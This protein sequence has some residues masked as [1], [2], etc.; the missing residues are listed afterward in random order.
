M[1][2]VQDLADAV[3]AGD[4]S[5][6]RILLHAKPDLIGTDMSEGDEH[7]A[8]HFAVLKR[9][10]AMVKLLM[11]AGA[12]AHKG[13]WPHRDATSA[14][15]IARER[16]YGEIVAIIEEEERRRREELSCPNATVAPVQEQINAAIAEHDNGL[17]IRLLEADGSLIHACDRKG[18]TPLHIAAQE[19]NEEMV[20]W[21]LHKRAKVNK[22]DLRDYTPLDRAALGADPRND[23]AK[24]FPAIATLLM[25]HGAEVTIYGAVALGGA[26]RVYELLQNDPSLLRRIDTNG[27]LVSLAVNHG[28]IEIAKLLLD[29]GAD[30]DERITLQAVEKPTASWGMLC[31]MPRWRMSATWLSCCSI[32]GQIR[33]P[34]C[35]HQAGRYEMP[36]ITKTSQSRNFCSR[37]A[38]SHSPIWLPRLT[39]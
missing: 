14:L 32:A 39:M 12:D 6:V 37:T 35:M 30:V 15:T 17:A 9:N 26:A 25:A 22:R 20:E 13:I 11:E 21:L 38:L 1:M 24:V 2:S 23:N 27:G 34:T 19:A 33:M 10:P 5:K 31:G 4:A 29:L 8:L 28:Q 3:N 7:R 36:G 16:G 18:A